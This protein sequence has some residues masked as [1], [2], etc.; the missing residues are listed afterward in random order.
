M[1]VTM[2]SAVMRLLPQYSFTV[3][4]TSYLHI[5]C[6]CKCR[7]DALHNTIIDKRRTNEKRKEKTVLF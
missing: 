3:L 2:M 6:V 7:V 4:L 1:R 5:V